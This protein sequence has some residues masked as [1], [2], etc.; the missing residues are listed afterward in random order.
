MKKLSI[1]IMLLLSVASLSVSAVS[2]RRINYQ[3][4]ARNASGAAI[5]STAV[6]LRISILDGSAV[7][8]EL[9]KE[10]HTVTTNAF[11]LFNVAIGDGTILS[12]NFNTLDWGGSD[13]YILVEIDPAGGTSYTSLGAN[14]LLGV[15]YANYADNAGNIYGDVNTVLK[16]T[17]P[18]TAGNSQIKDD[19]TTVTINS[20]SPVATTKLQIQNTVGSNKRGVHVTMG[21]FP[22][23]SNSTPTAFYGT[24]DSGFAF[25]GFSTTNSGIV[26]TTYAK[27]G[28]SAILGTG[29]SGGAGTFANGIEGRI[30]GSGNE[31]AAGLFSANGIGKGIV[32]TGGQSYFGASPSSLKY[33]LAVIQPSGTSAIADVDTNAAIYAYAQTTEACKKGGLYST[34]NTGN[35][36]VGL[37]GI[38]F[39][40]INYQ[41]RNSTFALSTGD[42]IGVYGSANSVGVEGTSTS[43]NGVRG[44]SSGIAAGVEGRG[45]TYGIYGNAST[46]GTTTAPAFRYGV[47][48]AASGAST[49]NFAGYFGGNVVVTGSL[50]KG[51]GTFKIDHP[52]DPENK[53]LYHSFVESPDMMNIYNGNITTNTSGFATV[54]LP[55][56]FDALN[57][58]FRY[59]L[60][61]IGTFA[62][63]II[64]EKVSGNK[65]V[66]QTN[67]PNVEVSWQ[68]TGVRH[69]K[70]ADAHRVVP[71]VEKETEFK[72]YYL[73]PTEWNQPEAKGIIELTKPKAIQSRQ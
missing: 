10:S 52:L 14:K 35:I 71:E 50:S 41:S 11:G 45:S 65:F 51:S 32:V 34:Y 15:P 24:C 27:D 7:G 1:I 66:I 23:L 69:D 70:F 63:A 29:S 62:Q 73:H 59:Q 16:F 37:Q 19:G 67:Q 49:A 36:G 13:K 5:A 31:G 38:G 54:T 3:G 72:G 8:P 55:S 25:F 44:I 56:Y 39:A 22:P 28:K 33:R 58:D 68:V 61:V 46:I 60:T 20:P 47:Y 6:G 4:V 57:K 26:G 18:N 9:Y 40:G 42:D 2:A 64:K 12:G 48:G 17:A 30:N 21:A 43:G 53:Y